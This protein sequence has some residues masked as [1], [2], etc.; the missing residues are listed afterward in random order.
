MSDFFRFV[1]A[2]SGVFGGAS[3][4]TSSVCAPS[5]F[6]D[7]DGERDGVELVESISDRRSSF[8]E[9]LL[10][11]EALQPGVVGTVEAIVDTEDCQLRR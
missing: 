4:A 11:T 8:R 5:A 3:M 6:L 1:T 10:A 2:A 7:G 9:K